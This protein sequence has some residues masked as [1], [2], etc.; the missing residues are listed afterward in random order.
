MGEELFTHNIVKTE[1]TAVLSAVCKKHR[2]G[3]VFSDRALL[4]NP[5]TTLSTEPDLVFAS[6]PR[7]RSGKVAFTRGKGDREVEIT[8]APDMV[9]EIISKWSVRKDTVELRKLY[10]LSGVNEYWIVDARSS[11]PSFQIMKRG[12]K[13]FIRMT[14]QAEGWMKSPVWD[15]SFRLLTAKDELGRPEYSLEVQ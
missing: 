15:A 5:Q 13:D 4:T 6:Y 12:K 7:I 9:L 8:G 10:W 2:L 3:Y 1:F 14:P 11:E